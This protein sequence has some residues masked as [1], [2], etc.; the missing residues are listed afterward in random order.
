MCSRQFLHGASLL[1][2]GVSIPMKLEKGQIVTPRPDRYRLTG[3]DLGEIGEVVEKPTNGFVL[4]ELD[5][6]ELY[7]ACAENWEVVQ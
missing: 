3:V 5:T 6:G 4:I 2:S 1:Q 7:L